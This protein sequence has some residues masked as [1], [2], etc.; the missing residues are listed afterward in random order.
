MSLLK[1]LLLFLPSPSHYNMAATKQRAKK[2]YCTNP[3]SATQFVL[4]L[5]R[6]MISLV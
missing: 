2:K 1:F 4:G 5:S 6:S 3:L